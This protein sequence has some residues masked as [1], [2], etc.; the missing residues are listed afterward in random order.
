M[1]KK[2]QFRGVASNYVKHFRIRVAL[3]YGLLLSNQDILDIIAM[4]QNHE[5]EYIVSKSNTKTVHKINFKGKEMLIGYSKSL[6]VPVTAFT[7]KENN[8]YEDELKEISE[9]EYK[10][11]FLNEWSGIPSVHEE[12]KPRRG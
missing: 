6:E 2:P 3:R 11:E 5:S 4:I 9:T 1:P 8:D 7:K 12:H 10:R